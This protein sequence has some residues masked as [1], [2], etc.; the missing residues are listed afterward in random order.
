MFTT[1]ILYALTKDEWCCLDVT[2]NFTSLGCLLDHAAN[3]KATLTPYK[4]LLVNA[5]VESWVYSLQG[6]FAGEELTS[7]YGCPQAA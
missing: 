1:G 4:P 7:D 6:L 3:A 2:R 5:D